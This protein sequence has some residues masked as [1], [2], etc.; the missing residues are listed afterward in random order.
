MTPVS[1]SIADIAEVLATYFDGLH[2][3]DTERLRK[4]FHP[5]ALYVTATAEPL[6]VWSMDDYL[7]VVEGRP[8]PASK[9]EAREDRI[10]SIELAGPVT[11]MA[12][13]ECRIAPRSFT[14]ILTLIHVDGRWQ[15]ISKVFHYDLDAEAACPT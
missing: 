12:R 13:V 7:P 11:S 15:I 3:S 2:H 14:D 1:E 9:G 5:Q 4:V 10:V 6:V 8:S